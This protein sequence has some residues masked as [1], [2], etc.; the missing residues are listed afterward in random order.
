[1]GL[2]GCLAR[3]YEMKVYYF[4]RPSLLTFFGREESK[5]MP[6]RQPTAVLSAQDNEKIILFLIA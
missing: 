1:V 2:C 3:R 5:C 6:H 4:A